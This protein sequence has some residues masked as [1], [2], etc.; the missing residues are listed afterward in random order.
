[1]EEKIGGAHKCNLDVLF[2]LLRFSSSILMLKGC[3]EDC[4]GSCLWSVFTPVAPVAPVA[5]PTLL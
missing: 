5:G 3:S 1:M 4:Q 2:Y